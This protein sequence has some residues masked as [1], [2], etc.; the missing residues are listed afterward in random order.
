M[1]K[2][3]TTFF[4]TGYTTAHKRIAI[5]GGGWKKIKF[6]ATCMLWEHPELGY[7]VWDTGYTP[8][9]F[10]ATQAWPMSIYRRS[11]PVT[12]I[13]EWTLAAQLKEK[14]IDPLEIKHVL[15]S[16][17][18]ADHIGGLR[19]FPNAHFWCSK[20]AWKEAQT[21]AGFQAVRR[22]FIP[23][24]LPDNFSAHLS[25]YENISAQDRSDPLQRHYDILGDGSLKIIYLPGHARGQMGVNFTR[26][27]G[28]EFL[29]TADAYWLSESIRENKYPSRLT[30]L[31]FDSRED[32]ERS[33]QKIRAFSH[34]NPQ[35]QLVSCH[36][37]ETYEQFVE[38]IY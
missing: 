24:F 11:T 31:F 9:F 29:Q 19:D 18:H 37:P 7:I 33:F 10:E 13:P 32:Y 15:I 12:C 30:N 20:T 2:L 23:A 3:K 21:L 14:N 4:T 6:H 8:R 38:K 27:D 5:R 22:G 16:H 28:L 26:I 1:T 36:C 35:V 25:F 34:Q 17:F